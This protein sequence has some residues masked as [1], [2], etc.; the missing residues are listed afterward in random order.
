MI[1]MKWSIRYVRST[2]RKECVLNI[3]RAKKEHG[4]AR[5]RDRI[6]K[7][8]DERRMWLVVSNFTGEFV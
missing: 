2:T 3:C 6:S 1:L 8:I 7:C 5:S 4:V